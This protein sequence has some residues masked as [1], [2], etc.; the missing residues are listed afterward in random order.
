[1]VWDPRE[2]EREKVIKEG[3]VGG[4]VGLPLFIIMD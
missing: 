3:K 4:V 2:K 1:M